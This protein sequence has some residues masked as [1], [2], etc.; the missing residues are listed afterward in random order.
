[1]TSILPMILLAP[2]LLAA[3]ITVLRDM[4]IPDVIVAGAIGLFLVT[5]PL[6]PLPELWLRFV[7]GLS[8]LIVGIAVFSFRATGASDLRFAA[9]VVLFVPSAALGSFGLLVA[10][11]LLGVALLSAT[12]RSSPAPAM[13]GWQVF[14]SERLPLG[15]ALVFAGLA[16]PATLAAGLF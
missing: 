7:A 12:L 2:V 4:R 13:D 8:V 10:I 15:L 14:G 9:A 5:S 3:A 11:G 6:V 1:M 16:L